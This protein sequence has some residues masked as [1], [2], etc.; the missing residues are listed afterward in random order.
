MGG[1]SEVPEV[2]HPQLHLEPVCGLGTGDR[3]DP[4]VVDQEVDRPSA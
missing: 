3:H 2:V 4:G 1:E